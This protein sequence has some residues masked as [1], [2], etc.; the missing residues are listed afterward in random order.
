MSQT[1]EHEKRLSVSNLYSIGLF[2]QN[3]R[4]SERGTMRLYL[5]MKDGLFSSL[6]YKIKSDL[7]VTSYR[8]K[9]VKASRPHPEQLTHRRKINCND[10]MGK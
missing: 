8:R 7:R 1:D 4:L 9:T 6:G 5:K 3:E 10:E 2:V